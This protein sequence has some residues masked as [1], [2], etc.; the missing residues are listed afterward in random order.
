M[1]VLDKAISIVSPKWGLKRANA[2][3][4]LDHISQIM[5]SSGYGNHGGSLSKRAL[6]GWN[7]GRGG[8]PDGD[9]TDNLSVLRS[10]SR[11]LYM[12]GGLAAGAIKTVATNVVGPGLRLNSQIDSDLLGMS[13]DVARAWERRTE[14]EF[15]LWAE[16]CNCDAAR[17]CDFYGLQ[18]LAFL[19]FLMNGDAFALLPMIR[20]PGVPYD[21]CVQLIEGDRVSDPLN[22]S[23]D[24]DIRE[25]V[26]VDK[27]G[28]PVAYYI[29][30]AHPGG[31]SSSPGVALRRRTWVRMPAF[32]DAT[33]RRNVL[34][35]MDPERIEQRRGV[36][37]L[38]PVIEDIKQLGRYS[39][40]ELMSAVIGGLMTVFVTSDL[41]QGIG[42]E[43][44]VPFGDSPSVSDDPRSI[45][46]GNG[47]VVALDPGEKID[48]VDPK[49]PNV[50][51]DG[52]ITSVS[53]QIGAA[54]GL[55]YEVLVKQFNAS[56][57]ASRASL[58]EAWKSFRTWRFWFVGAFCRPVY[59]S[60][61]EEAVARGRIFA[62]GFFDD[63]MLRK[64]YC[65]AV[66]NG[67]CQGQI[68]PVQEVTAAKIR[69]EEGFSTRTQET[70]ELTG[71]DWDRN[72]RQR[73]IEEQ[74]RQNGGLVS[75]LGGGQD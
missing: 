70:A 51:F 23:M 73:V 71:G 58:L 16:S 65:G 25:G 28:A 72:N 54:L 62:P 11:D 60:W 30:Q 22:K 50:A 15:A 64:A 47:T 21:L 61:L 43:P 29:C 48:T 34:H 49:R 7:S 27:L 75:S 31:T 74:A 39:K 46:L 56:Y 45:E 1:N 17:T 33:G 5:A 57:S 63:P 37:F 4:R 14:Q 3:I 41:Q 53:R 69:V 40:A 2:R 38:A 8:D 59:E 12:E 24:K 68:N 13:G 52:F 36:P 9:I 19:S 18:R 26:E 20:R 32:G 44:V 66:W 10:R 67:P 35:L 42:G 55:P 6:L